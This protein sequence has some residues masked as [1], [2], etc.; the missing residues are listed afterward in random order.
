[1]KDKYQNKIVIAAV[2]YLHPISGID[3]NTYMNSNSLTIIVKESNNL[4]ENAKVT[5][6][7]GNII[8]KTN[9]EG[10]FLL[11]IPS[12]QKK[13]DIKV[14]SNNNS[15]EFPYYISN[16]PSQRLEVNLTYLQQIKTQQ[17]KELI[18]NKPKKTNSFS[19]VFIIL[20]LFF[21]SIAIFN[22]IN[23]SKNK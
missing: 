16:E 21:I 1:L 3:N 11:T 22:S 12:N 4:I 10:Q 5:I 23:K 14:E 20:A 13:L 9:K 19:I 7:P 6:N 18:Q 8:G 15:Q 2:D 17:A